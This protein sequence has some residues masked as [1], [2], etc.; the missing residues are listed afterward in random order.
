MTIRIGDFAVVVI[1]YPCWCGFSLHKWT[2]GPRR[3]S[4]RHGCAYLGRL[5][6]VW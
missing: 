5:K 1:Y 3:S 6:L 2:Y 4:W